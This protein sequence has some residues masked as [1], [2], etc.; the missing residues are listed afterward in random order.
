MQALQDCCFFEFTENCRH[1]ETQIKENYIFSEIEL[2]SERSK[3]LKNIAAVPYTIILFYTLFENAKCLELCSSLLR[4]IISSDLRD[5]ILQF[6]NRIY[7]SQIKFR[8]K[9]IDKFFSFKV[10]KSSSVIR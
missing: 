3:L 2:R 7:N 5:S 10:E 8:Y 1:I 6:L 9:L 4:D